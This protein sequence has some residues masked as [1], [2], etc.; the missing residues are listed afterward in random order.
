M[1][2]SSPRSVPGPRPPHRSRPGTRNTEARLSRRRS[3]RVDRGPSCSCMHAPCT[4]AREKTDDR[5]Y[6]CSTI[7]VRIRTV[8]YDCGTVVTWLGRKHRSLARTHIR[9]AKESGACVGEFF[10]K[11][12]GKCRFGR[13][14]SGQATTCTHMCVTGS[15]ASVLSPASLVCQA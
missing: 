13:H 2:G 10:L 5:A 9:E 14:G 7:V 12:P 8:M 1:D 15:T 4:V 6:S 3:G 11:R